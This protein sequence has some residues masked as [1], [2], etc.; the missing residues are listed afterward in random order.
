MH[1]QVYLALFLYVMVRRRY[2][3]SRGR[4]LRRRARRYRLSKSMRMRRRRRTIRR[5][6]R[7]GGLTVS[8]SAEFPLSYG[9]MLPV[10][11]K[12]KGSDVGVPH[13]G[14]LTWSICPLPL[15]VP[16][17]LGDLNVLSFW[18]DL[19]T[20]YGKRYEPQIGLGNNATDET[21][22]LCDLPVCLSSFT[23]RNIVKCETLWKLYKLYRISWVSVTF[24]VPE[25]TGGQRN[26]NL[27]IEWTH[28]PKARCAAYEDCL[29]M[30]V[31]AK[32]QSSDTGGFNWIY[33]PPDIATA[34]SIDGRKNGRNGWRRAQL[35]YNHP[36]TISWR[37][38]HAELIQDH[39]NY[40][41][42]TSAST[43][44]TKVMD[45]W[46]TKDKFVRSYLPTD[47]D[48]QMTAERQLWAGPVI[49][50]IDADIT[51]AS[52]PTTPPSNTW[53]AQYGIR[54]TC[55]VKIKFKN[56]DAADPIFPEYVP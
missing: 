30:V 7:R 26:H 44:G 24:T 52:I 25:F 27:Y 49:R 28:L 19:N 56:M 51:A 2:R 35:A 5:S 37:P 50:L 34:C 8:G 3:R 6:R 22:M 39:I 45:L 17:V 48:Q 31:P 46:P 13:D 10:E 42:A 36:V 53:Y 4:L 32:G 38:K 12:A 33:N 20:N 15:G 29:G 21:K 47:I 43:G 14:F 18:V 23:V 16:Q 11:R 9:S 1:W 41:D 55:V 54:C 40:W